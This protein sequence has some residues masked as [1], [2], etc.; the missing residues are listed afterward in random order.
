MIN[1]EPFDHNCPSIEAGNCGL[2]PRE[3]FSQFLIPSIA[4]LPTGLTN[5]FDSNRWLFPS[6]DVPPS[7]KSGTTCCESSVNNFGIDLAF[8]L[9]LA[10]H[11]GGNFRV[12]NTAST[13]P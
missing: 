7:G 13:Y 11:L 4:T 5:V 9:P 6:M 1:F 12:F 2:T 3:E 8:G 10:S